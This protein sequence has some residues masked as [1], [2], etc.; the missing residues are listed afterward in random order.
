M[1]RHCDEMKIVKKVFLVIHDFFVN[2]I[3]HSS[4]Y[5]V[6]RQSSSHELEYVSAG[7]DKHFN[8]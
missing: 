2:E 4:A 3:F 5:I 1:E 8:P 6:N 7:D